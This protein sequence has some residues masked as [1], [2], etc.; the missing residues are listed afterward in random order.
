MICVTVRLVKQKNIHLEQES[1]EKLDAMHGFP[2]KILITAITFLMTEKMTYEKSFDK[3]K[4]N[5]KEKESLLK[6]A[7][8]A[9]FGLV[10]GI[11][12]SLKGEAKKI[13]WH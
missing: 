5:K 6:E 10:E 12:L 2:K 8:Q 9:S 13:T 7:I 4:I 3:K 1:L 11:D